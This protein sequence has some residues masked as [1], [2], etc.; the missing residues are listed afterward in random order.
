MPW[1][2]ARSVGAAPGGR[3]AVLQ[4]LCFLASL[5]SCPW[6]SHVLLLPTSDQVCPPLGG[7]R[8]PLQCQVPVPQEVGGRTARPPAPSP[9]WGSLAPFHAGLRPCCSLHLAYPFL[10]CAQPGPPRPV[11]AQG[12][13]LHPPPLQPGLL[14]AIPSVTEHRACSGCQ[15]GCRGHGRSGQTE[16]L[17]FGRWRSRGKQEKPRT[18]MCA[19]SD[20]NVRGA[21]DE[22]GQGSGR[23]LAKVRS[24]PKAPRSGGGSRGESGPC[25]GPEAGACQGCGRSHKEP[26]VIRVKRGGVDE[27]KEAAATAGVE[28]GD[29]EPTE[30]ALGQ[31]PLSLFQGPPQPP[32]T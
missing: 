4:H 16:S 31:Q 1:T 11:S 20:T 10:L 23:V 2:Q 28:E 3:R 13:F 32:Q 17:P 6:L 29:G 27:A 25:K 19:M 12:S 15:S 7:C 9:L 30:P 18:A 24:E 14:S 26:R 21:Q 8:E 5:Y 22:P